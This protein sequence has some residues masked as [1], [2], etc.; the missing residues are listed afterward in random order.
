MKIYTRSGDQG[1]TGRHGGERVA[2]DALCIETTGTVDELNCQIGLA[3][4]ACLHEDLAATL[5][6]IQE[7]LFE[8][9]ADLTTPR[10]VEDTAQS[11]PRITAQHIIEVEGQID[12]VW[13]QLEPLRSFILPGGGELAARLHV[14]R[15]VCRRAER[16]CVALQRVEPLSSEMLVYVNRLSDLLFALARRA[17]QLDDVPDTPWTPSPGVSPGASPGA[18]SGT[19][20]G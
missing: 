13:E 2:K 4:A 8:F 11:V 6:I 5:R 16:L 12:A 15:A 1:S 18:S 3:L 10:A 17:N 19:T 9:G 14:A 7:R 20:S